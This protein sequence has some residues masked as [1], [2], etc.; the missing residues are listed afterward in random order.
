[1]SV[2]T[3]PSSPA[4]DVPGKARSGRAFIIGCIIFLVAFVIFLVA[5]SPRLL[6]WTLAQAPPPAPQ[7][8]AS[9]TLGDQ[10]WTATAVE[11]DEDEVPC[12]AL[13][14]GGTT[15]RFCGQEQARGAGVHV[16]E[17]RTA[18]DETLLAVLASPRLTTFEVDHAEG[19]V[20]FEPDYVDFGF[21]V[22]Y[23]VTDVPAQDVTITARDSGDEV[24]STVTCDGSE[25]CEVT[26]LAD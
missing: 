13:V 4:P 1:M 18:G 19:S 22:G 20:T 15:E 25:T 14:L 7:Q 3:P 24:G 11:G 5:G 26:E 8:V 10:D 16:A 12:L 9:G 23:V 21:P 2:T 6:D 17:M